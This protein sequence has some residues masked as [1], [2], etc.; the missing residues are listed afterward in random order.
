MKIEVRSAEKKGAFLSLDLNGVTREFFVVEETTKY[1]TF[2][3]SLV[4]AGERIY[5]SATLEEII[6]KMSNTYGTQIVTGPKR[7]QYF[8]GW[9]GTK[10]VVDFHELT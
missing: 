3:S 6:E 10:H 8:K 7:Y 5:Y 4:K 2:S 9:V 1:S